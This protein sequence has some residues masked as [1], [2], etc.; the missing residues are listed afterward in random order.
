MRP[1]EEYKNQ[2]TAGVKLEKFKALQ[3]ISLSSSFGFENKAFVG[4][5][6]AI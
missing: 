3:N 6:P 2:R 4:F 1:S 5:Y